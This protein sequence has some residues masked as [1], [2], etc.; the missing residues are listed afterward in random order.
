MNKKD[1]LIKQTNDEGL[2]RM[3]YSTRN[4]IQTTSSMLDNNNTCYHTPILCNYNQQHHMN[5]KA[6]NKNTTVEFK[7]IFYT[8]QNNFWQDLSDF[9]NH[10]YETKRD[11][12][13]GY[14]TRFYDRNIKLFKK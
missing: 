9:D 6:D 14:D 10:I 3:G 11:L 13:V 7:P 4:V 8:N 2:I 12:R 5:I 1:F